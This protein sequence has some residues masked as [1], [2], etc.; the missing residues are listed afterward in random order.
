MEQVD[1]ANRTQ[2]ARE[3]EP[4]WGTEGANRIERHLTDLSRKEAKCGPP[5]PHSVFLLNDGITAGGSRGG[6]RAGRL[7]PAVTV[8][9]MLGQRFTL[10][11]H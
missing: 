7:S 5:D 9:N 10:L 6:D 8:I 4:T 3:V 11:V 1:Q 2:G